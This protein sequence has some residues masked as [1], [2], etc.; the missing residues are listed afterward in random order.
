MPGVFEGVGAWHRFVMN[1]N[2]LIGDDIAH[3]DVV[4]LPPEL[5]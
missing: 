1:D 2:L 5:T 3:V 4:V